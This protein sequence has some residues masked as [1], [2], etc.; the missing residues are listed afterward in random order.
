MVKSLGFLGHALPFSQY[1]RK[2]MRLF[3]LERNTYIVQYNTVTLYVQSILLLMQRLYNI[4]YIPIQLDQMMVYAFQINN[5][6]RFTMHACVYSTLPHSD[7]HA[8]VLML[9]NYTCND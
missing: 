6:I 2:M 9:R 8:C 5:I 4:I 7:I 1:S 3:I